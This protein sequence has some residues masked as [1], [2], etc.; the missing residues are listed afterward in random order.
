MYIKG[1]WEILDIL[2][3]LPLLACFLGPSLGRPPWADGRCRACRQDRCPE[4]I[5][6]HAGCQKSCR[7]C[8]PLF[9]LT[10]HFAWTPRHHLWHAGHS[11]NSAASSHVLNDRYSLRESHAT[12]LHTGF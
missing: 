1:K 5:E 9:D 2:R 6:D 8:H 4:Q 7:C 3:F 12:Q 10:D 11:E